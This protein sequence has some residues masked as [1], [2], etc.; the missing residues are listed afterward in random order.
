MPKNT[1]IKKTEM[2]YKVIFEDLGAIDYKEAWDYQEGIFNRIVDFKANKAKGNQTENEPDSYVLFCEHPHV[3]TLGKS[4]EQENL[5]ITESYLKQIGAGFY[6][7]NRG[8]DITYHGPGQIVG[9]PI[10]DLSKLKIGIKE[11]IYKLEE[12]II[13]ALK[14]YDIHA[15]R[16]EKAT[17]VWLGEPGT[18][19]ERK[20]CAIGVRA[21]RFV[22]MH[23]FAMN[24]NTDLKYF[25]H[26]NPC[27]FTDKQVTSVEKELERKIDFAEAKQIVK[28]KVAEVFDFEYVS[29]KQ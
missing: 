4:G 11:Y 14:E 29:K 23:G 21:G 20:I 3:Y 13:L 8:G 15:Q 9:Y 27:G 10:I 5:L 24:I 17:G 22:T 18:S 19:G 28:T 1:F 6:K 2:S 26:I 7:I 12:S 25:K 16:K